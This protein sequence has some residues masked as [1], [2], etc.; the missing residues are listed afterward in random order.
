MLSEYMITENLKY[1]LEAYQKKQE[2]VLVKSL[3]ASMSLCDLKERSSV[4]Y[5]DAFILCRV[6]IC[7]HG[8]KSGNIQVHIKR[9]EK[10]KV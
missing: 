5:N 2:V 6:C 10:I 9:T 4:E 3:I 7:H 1:L 8:K